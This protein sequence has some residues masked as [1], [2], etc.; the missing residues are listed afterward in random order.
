[1]ADREYSYSRGGASNTAILSA[2]LAD[3]QVNYPTAT[4]VGNVLTVPFKYQLD[5]RQGGQGLLGKVINRECQ[6]V[7]VIVWAPD[8]ATRNVLAKAIDV[9]IKPNPVVTLADQSDAKIIYQ[10]TVMMDDPQNKGLFRR[11]LI[12]D[13]EFATIQT[14]PGFTITTVNTTVTNQA[15]VDPV[16]VSTPVTVTN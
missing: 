9:A 10:R 11:D 6:Q 14:F 16:V 13:V 5:V 1:M 7:S 8:P 3:I 15:F 2:L 12:Y 4:L